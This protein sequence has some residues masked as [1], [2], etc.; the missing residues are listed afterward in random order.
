MPLDSTSFLPAARRFVAQI[1][2]RRG[3]VVVAPVS[4][5]M[6]MTALLQRRIAV[7]GQA[8]I[9]AVLHTA[10]LAQ[11][12]PSPILYAPSVRRAVKEMISGAV[13]YFETGV[14]PVI[15]KTLSTIQNKS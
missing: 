15:R 5:S 3:I 4:V 2:G 1:S 8:E 13:H 14:V 12:D 6:I 11:V 10:A 9:I 7:P